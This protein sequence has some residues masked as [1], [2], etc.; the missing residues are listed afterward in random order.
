MDV[1]CRKLFS[2]FVDEKSSEFKMKR[3]TEEMN[4]LKY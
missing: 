3:L 1:L 2:L 4:K